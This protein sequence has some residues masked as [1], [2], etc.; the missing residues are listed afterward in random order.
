MAAKRAAGQAAARPTCGSRR[1]VEEACGGALECG[2][3]LAE[4]LLMGTYQYLPHKSQPKQAS[5]RTLPCGAVGP[6]FQKG[7][8]AGNLLGQAN[9]FTRDLQNA[10]GN[11]MRPRDLAAAA[12]KLARED[13]RVRVKVLDERAM[14][15]LGDGRAAGR[16]ERIRRAG[17]A[18]PPDL[19]AQGGEA[20]KKA[21][22]R[23]GGQGADLR[24]RRHQPQAGPRRCGT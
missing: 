13:P 20:K 6:R 21:A 10:P 4:G 7:V 16:L 2:T 3:C 11:C 17:A 12:R 5:L 23:P 14:K 24:R 22:R 19:H 18:D 1:S 8:R 15:Q 9:C